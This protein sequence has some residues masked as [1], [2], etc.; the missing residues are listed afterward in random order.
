MT[1]AFIKMK[2]IDQADALV[3]DMFTLYRDRPDFVS[4][5]HAVKSAYWKSG[6]QEKSQVLCRR[7]LSEFPQ[8]PMAAKILGDWICGALVLGQEEGVNEKIETLFS[9]YT[10]PAED[11][12]PA[13]ARI[14][15]RYLMRNDYSKV[16]E[17]GRRA[18]EIYPD[19]PETVFVSSYMAQAMAAMGAP[20]QASQ[21]ADTLISKYGDHPQI[22]QV[23]IDVGHAFRRYGLYRKSV[24]L[25]QQV[26]SAKC[27][28]PEKLCALTGMAQSCIRMGKDKEAMETTGRILSGYRGEKKLGYSVFVIGEEY[29]ILAEEAFQVSNQKQAEP[30]YRKAVAVWEKNRSIPEDPKHQAHAAYYCGR[31]YQTLGEYEKAMDYYR[32]VL[33]KWPTYEK[34]KG[35]EYGLILCYQKMGDNRQATL[36]YNRAALNDPS[37]DLTYQTEPG[38]LAADS[39]CGAYAVWHLLRYYGRP[40]SIQTLV[41]QMEIPQKGYSTL[42]DIAEVFAEYEISVQAVQIPP[43]KAS[44]L[45]KPFVQYRLPAEEG[46]LGHFVLCIPI[47]EKVLVLDGQKEPKLID[48]AAL[49][50]S[51][52]EVWD[53]TL[54]L[55]ETGRQEYLENDISNQISWQGSLH[56]GYAWFL[57]ED[58]GGLVDQIE[59]YY[60]ALSQQQIESIKGGCVDYDCLSNGQFC[61]NVPVCAGSLNC[62][63]SDYYCT[64]TAAGRRCMRH[65][66]GILPCITLTAHTCSPELPLTGTCTP[67]YCDVYVS[68]G[69]GGCGTSV[70]RCRDWFW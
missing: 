64:D 49:D 57:E 62:T 44:E 66:G 15:E 33:E 52:E 11:F 19:H 37:P 30:A 4:F 63:L 10:E 50:Q 1:E 41:R 23:L 53:G 56:T 9:R 59:P 22:G 34:I 46:M 27:P 51:S 36:L 58:S 24:E 12:L 3:E 40:V 35:V 54:L 47:G 32:E 2:K 13:A 17:T 28:K 38:F 16:I 55:I 42:Q 67:P 14:Q 26:Q 65:P 68:P 61:Y 29:Y 8:N 21:M 60:A 43:E 6:Q 25:Y 39:Y 20:Q 7:L 70:P 5:M 48:L 18:L 31:V 69:T 45:A